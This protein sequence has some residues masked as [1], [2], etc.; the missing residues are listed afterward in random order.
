MQLLGGK[1]RDEAVLPSIALHSDCYMRFAKSSPTTCDPRGLRRLPGRLN[2]SMVALVPRCRRNTTQFEAP[3]GPSGSPCGDRIS[4]GG[5]VL[6]FHSI[7]YDLA[8]VPCHSRL[9]KLR[10][11]GVLNVRCQC[12]LAVESAGVLC[13]L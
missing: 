2:A 7:D 13:L 9:I 6:N 12:V 1:S 8:D 5:F 10:H 4:V 3:R 11:V